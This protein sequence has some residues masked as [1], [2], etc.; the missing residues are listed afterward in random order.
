MAKLGSKIALAGRISAIT[1]IPMTVLTSRNLAESSVAQR[2]SWAASRVTTRA[3][4]GAYCLLGLF[5]ANMSLL[6][7]EGQRAFFRLQEEIIKYNDDH[8]IFCLVNEG[9]EN[10]RPTCSQ[11]G[12]LFRM[13]FFY[14]RESL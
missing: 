6:Y 7:G 11:S 3:E 5:G 10:F 13:S 12:L 2:M 8:S 14:R 9:N 4:D 1:R